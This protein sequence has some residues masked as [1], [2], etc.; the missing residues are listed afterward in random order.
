MHSGRGGLDLE[1]WRGPNS[2]GRWCIYIENEDVGGG[3]AAVVCVRIL[4]I[5]EDASDNAG[6]VLWPKCS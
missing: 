1:R 6:S 5:L 4:C 2:C 3:S